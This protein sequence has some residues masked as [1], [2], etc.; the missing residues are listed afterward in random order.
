[1]MLLL[2][3]LFN[4]YGE[5]LI[6]KAPEG[7]GDFK[8]GHVIHALKYADNLVLLAKEEVVIIGIG[9]CYGLEMDEEETKVIRISKQPSPT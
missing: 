4:L 2:P 8:I 6:K 9:R 5:Y 1:M 7:F 3:I